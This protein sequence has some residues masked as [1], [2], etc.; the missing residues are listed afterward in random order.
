MKEVQASRAGRA[1]RGR[2]RG[3]GP[4]AE[5]DVVAVDQPVLELETEKAVVEVPCSFAGKVVKVHVHQGEHVPVGAVLL[6]ID[7]AAKEGE[8]AA[9]PVT[10]APSVPTVAAETEPMAA[11]TPTPAPAVAAAA[12]AT[13][14][15]TAPAVEELV[16]AGPAT[17]RLARELGVDLHEVA[18]VHPGARLTECSPRTVT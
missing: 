8:T 7:T 11:P 14:K 10:E 6:T 3:S 2:R 17:R 12:P 5:G 13:A 4:G 18:A 15:A 1:H 16:P 9:A